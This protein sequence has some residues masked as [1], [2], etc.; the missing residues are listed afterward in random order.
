MPELHPYARY[1]RAVMLALAVAVA[2][3]LTMFGLG[4]SWMQGA[5]LDDELARIEGSA[6]RAFH[7]TVQREAGAMSGLLTG[8]VLDETLRRPFLAQDRTGLLA[9]ARPVFERLREFHNV[10]HFYFLDTE[11]RVFLRVHQPD[12]YGDVVFRAS[13]REAQSAERVSH[14]VEMGPLGTLTLRVVLPWRDAEQPIGFLELGMDIDAALREA[15]GPT[16]ADLFVLVDKRHLDRE[17]WE[18]SRRA[19]G[20]VPDWARFPHHVLVGHS[21]GADPALLDRYFES[22]TQAASSERFVEF[23][24]SSMHMHAAPLRE[25]DGGEI[26]M[27]VVA[28]DV[29]ADGRAFSRLMLRLGLGSLLVGGVLLAF[30]HLLLTRLEI[31]LLSAERERDVFARRSRVDSLT[32]LLNQAEFYRLLRRELAREGR[33]GSPVAV[34]MFDLD[35]FKRINDTWGHQA[36]DAVLRAVARMISEGV[37]PGDQVARY[38][39]EEFVM[40]L[41]GLDLDAALQIAE[42]VRARV[43]ASSIEAR[44]QTIHITLSGGVA[45]FPADAQDAAG[46]VAAADTALYRAKHGGRDRVVA[47]RGVPGSVAA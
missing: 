36:G 18:S 31:R 45:V 44:G 7:A 29:T 24:P 15:D 34:A 40:L 47:F 28:H 32:A 46:L 42:R 39:G 33:A 9:A 25:A 16:G 12:R 10:T 14:A 38:G 8:L 43:A 26:A 3:L 23:G 19:L 27:M 11:R 13:A 4:V 41:P 22:G 35:H 2:L 21:G 37:R 20:R 1:R 17:Q 6:E 5:H 30:F